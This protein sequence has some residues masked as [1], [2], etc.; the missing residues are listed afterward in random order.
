[1]LEGGECQVVIDN[2]VDS[3]EKE[4]QSAY[5]LPRGKDWRAAGCLQQPC[6]FKEGLSNIKTRGEKRKRKEKERLAHLDL[7]SIN[8]K[9]LKFIKVIVLGFAF[10]I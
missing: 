9:M 2:H 5:R 10:L 1:M 8:P 7:F 3:K 4:L 6:G